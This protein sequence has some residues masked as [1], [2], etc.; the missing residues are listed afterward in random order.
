MLLSLSESKRF[1][2]RWRR[3]LKG[4]LY[5]GLITDDLG[6]RAALGKFAILSVSTIDRLEF[7]VIETSLRWFW[8][9]AR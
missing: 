6:V 4:A 8:L 1:D 3:G 9:T 7:K 2:D 5:S